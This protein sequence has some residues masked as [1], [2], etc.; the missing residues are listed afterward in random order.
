MNIIDFDDHYNIHVVNTHNYHFYER[1]L[2]D[3]NVCDPNFLSKS[4]EEL[5]YM[6]LED[7]DNYIGLFLTDKTNK[8]LYTSMIIDVDCE[9]NKE[10]IIE[11]GY[12]L[13]ESCEVVLLCTNNTIRIPRLTTQFV[14]FVFANLIKLFKP[15]TKNIFLYV[16]QGLKDNHHAFMFY[17][18][19]G[20]VS[21]SDDNP[22]IM[23][24]TYK[25]GK[26]KYKRRKTNKHIKNKTNK[27]RT[28]K[29]RKYI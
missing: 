8:N 6:S 24:Y 22:N 18:K 13:N 19:L 23:I 7:A 29:S 5:S 2:E 20:F 14:N 21:L 4:F 11:H 9:K 15:T 16:A 12:N 3:L 28:N 17:N 25:G 26:R 10:A 27:R 1:F